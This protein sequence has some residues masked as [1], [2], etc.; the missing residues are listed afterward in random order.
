[1]TS[2]GNMTHNLTHDLTLSGSSPTA[3]NED[4]GHNFTLSGP[5]SDSNAS[6][7]SSSGNE[8]EKIQEAG[9]GSKRPQLATLDPATYQKLVDIRTTILLGGIYGMTIGCFVGFAIHR[10]IDR[11]LI[12]T[13]LTKKFSARFKERYP[14]YTIPHKF[15]RHSLLPTV[16]FFGAIVSFSSASVNGRSAL[17][18][19]GDMWSLNSKPKSAY[20]Q[21]MNEEKRALH[22]SAEE[23]FDR[24]IISIREG[25]AI[26]EELEKWGPPTK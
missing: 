25:K 16:L 9:L 17:N 12:R 4:I 19:V 18:K 26:K 1:M 3:P 11:L 6:S 20:Q 10:G 22:K 21:Q 8:T 24:R 23:S 5:I 13:G 7:S 2:T 15:P 14:A